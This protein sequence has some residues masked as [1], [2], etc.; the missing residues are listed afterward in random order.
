MHLDYVIYLAQFQS[1]FSIYEKE[2]T[3]LQWSISSKKVNSKMINENLHNDRQSLKWPNAK[4]ILIF[5]SLWI[6]SIILST[7]KK[8]TDAF[9]CRKEYINL[10]YD[11]RLN[12]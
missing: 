11:T 5:H 10:Q 4:C 1:V 9:L 6:I 7:S 8:A 3:H 2:L 12:N